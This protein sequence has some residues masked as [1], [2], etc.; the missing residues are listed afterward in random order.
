MTPEEKELIIL[1]AKA[2]G[3]EWAKFE[4]DQLF[5]IP[6]TECPEAF[7]WN[8]LTSLSD[9]AAMC[10]QL[11]IDIYWLPDCKVVEAVKVKNGYKCFARHQV[12]YTTDKSAACSLACLRVAAEIGKQLKGE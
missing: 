5:V 9:R 3:Y 8:P 2:M 6:N 7:W 10:D 4:G 1:A 11:E 12:H